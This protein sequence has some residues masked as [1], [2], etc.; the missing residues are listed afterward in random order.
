VGAFL[1]PAK[2][3]VAWAAVQAEGI[4]ELHQKVAAATAEFGEPPEAR[5]FV[6][7]AT[8]ARLDRPTDLRPWVEAHQDALLAAGVLR[9]LVLYRS[10]L[11]RQGAI[12]VREAVFPL[13]APA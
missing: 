7:H 1:S 10:E 8:L 11:T 3:K 13:L 2:A 4:Q 9:E 5:P 6:P 12:H